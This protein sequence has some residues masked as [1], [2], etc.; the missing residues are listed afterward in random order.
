ME[1]YLQNFNAEQKKQECIKNI[2]EYFIK[3]ENRDCNCVVGITGG[4]TSTLLAMLCK[5]ALGVD[6]VVGICLEDE[7]YNRY[8]GVIADQ[9]GIKT[10]T[11]DI[12][13]AT[14]TIYGLISFGFDSNKRIRERISNKN[15]F[16]RDSIV[17][18]TKEEIFADICM[19]V[20]KA[21]GKNCNGRIM[22]ISNRTQ[23]WLGR[24]SVFDNG[25][26]DF[27]PLANLTLSEIK[28]ILELWDLRF[29]SDLF[30]KNEED[31]IGYDYSVVDKYILTGQIDDNKLKNEL[32]EIHKKKG[33]SVK[34]S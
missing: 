15:L 26:G 6:R 30:N 21:I 25:G 9:L 3:E 20:T 32:D 10:I 11:M 22:N 8:G 33:I 16:Y 27:A 31:S 34:E 24:L 12:P 28:K 17:D 13:M 5:E 18:G 1:D 14:D 2:K 29:M 19:S 23:N 4:T 7:K